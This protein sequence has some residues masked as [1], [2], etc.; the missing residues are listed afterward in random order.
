MLIVAV[1]TAIYLVLGGYVA[2]AITDFVQ[3]LI[4]L[5][6]VGA[7]IVAVLLRPE[8]G[9]LIGGFEKLAAI[10]PQLVTPFGGAS[11]EMLLVNIALTSFGVW[12][13][14]QMIHKYYAIKDERSIKQAT[15]IATL[16]ALVMGCGAYLVGCFGRLFVPANA[17]GAPDLAAG[18]DGVVPNLLMQVLSGSVLTNMILSI[19]LLLLLSASMSTLAAIVLSSSS[20]LAVDLIKVVQPK[21]APQRQLRLIR[22]LCLL[23]VALSFAFATMNISFIVNLM[24][25]SWGIVAGCFIGPYLW[26]LYSKRVTRAGAWAGALSGLVVVL[27]LAIYTTATSG[28]AAAKSLAPEFGVAAMVVSLLAVP[29][30]SLFTKPFSKEHTDRVFETEAAPAVPTAPAE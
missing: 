29:L 22:L 5:V 8:V 15:I 20:A 27:A 30:V 6:G 3:G 10:D 17:A 12:G 4:M 26:G 14:P 21:I 11:W 25:F 23:F 19:I 7:M 13:L 16:F 9:G 18:Y 24:S 2:T 1:L 28:F